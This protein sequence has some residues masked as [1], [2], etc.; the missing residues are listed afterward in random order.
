MGTLGDRM[1]AYENDERLPKGAAVI[2]VDGKAFHTW[3][4]K[5]HLD[6]P[7]DSLMNRYMNAAAL[8]CMREMQG[9]RLAY[10]QS[11]ESTF[12]LTNLKEKE[13]SWFDYKVQ[14]LASLT[15]SMFTYYFNMYW[16]NSV[17]PAFFDARA[18]SIPIED[19]ANVLVWR[20]QDNARNYIQS[21]ANFNYP[22]KMVIGRSNA[23]LTETLWEDGKDP[24]KLPKWVRYGTFISR[25]SDGMVRTFSRKLNY[26]DINN[27][28]EIK[29]NNDSL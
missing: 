6:R 3:T 26:D 10:T 4:R 18:F 23:E 12:I 24:D 25:T 15:A 20:Q 21:W 28:L 29:E 9:C 8:S 17:P 7:F 2:R 22:R 11:D 16:E 5:A 1:K 14:K 19:V 27:Y 13:Q